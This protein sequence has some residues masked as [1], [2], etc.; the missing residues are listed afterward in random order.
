[1]LGSLNPPSPT[2][3]DIEEWSLQRWMC[4]NFFPG[5]LAR[6]HR[7]PPFFDSASRNMK[8]QSSEPTVSG[9]GAALG[10]FFSQGFSGCLQLLFQSADIT[11]CLGFDDAELRVDVLVFITGVFFILEKRQKTIGAEIFRSPWAT[12]KRQPRILVNSTVISSTC[13][14]PT[15]TL[16]VS[17]FCPVLLNPP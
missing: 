5:K 1:M 7:I 10:R 16:K 14:S 4:T 11:V 2:Q 13:S 15:K 8:L 17:L 3:G 12:Q 6:D 9:H